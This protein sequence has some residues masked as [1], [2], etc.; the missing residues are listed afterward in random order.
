M[1][2]QRLTTFGICQLCHATTAYPFPMPQLPATWQSP[3]SPN[4]MD[5][6]LTIQRRALTRPSALGEIAGAHGVHAA[7]GLTV[8]RKALARPSALEVRAG[9]HEFFAA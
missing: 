2:W 8:Q 9:A 5:P 7:W 1:D 3:P 4:M 6:G